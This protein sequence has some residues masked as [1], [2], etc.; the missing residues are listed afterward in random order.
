[1]YCVMGYV[2]LL[3]CLLVLCFGMI[4]GGGYKPLPAVKGVN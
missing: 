2:W 4:K 1:M 3:V